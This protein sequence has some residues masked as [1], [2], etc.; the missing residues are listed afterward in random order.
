MPGS[1]AS[2][3]VAWTPRLVG[4]AAFAA[5]VWFAAPGPYWMDSQELAAAAVRLGVPHPTGFP[6]FCVVGKLA[7]LLPLGEL[8]VRV[9]W[10]TAAFAALTLAQVARLVLELAGEDGSSAVGAALAAIALGAGSTFFRAA[11][12]TEVYAPTALAVVVALR[13][14]LALLRQPSARV[15]V[16][17]GLLVGVAGIGLHSSFRLLVGPV[18]LLMIGY[19]WRRRW[20]RGAVLLGCVGALGMLA[21]LPL[22]SAS[23]RVAALDWGHPSSLGAIWDH[24]TAARIRAAYGDRMLAGA[25]LDDAVTFAGQLEADL[26]VLFLLAA[27]LGIAAL[28]PRARAFTVIVVAFVIADAAYAVVLNPMGIAERQNGVPLSVGVA[29]LAGV[30][31]ALAGRR[32]GGTLGGPFVTLTLGVALA[33]QP[34]LAGGAAKLAV[35]MSD[36]PRGWSEAALAQTPTGGIVLAHN[37][38]LAAGL[39]WLAQ[40]ERARPDAAALVRQH[41]WDRRR[42]RAVLAAIGVAGDDPLASG[43]PIRWELG[44]DRAPGPVAPDVPVGS[45]RGPPGV[46][47]TTEARLGALFAGRALDDPP[48][49]REGAR[50]YVNLGVLYAMAHQPARAAAAAERALA[51]DPRSGLAAANAALYRLQAGDAALARAHAELALARDPARATPWTVLGIL[52]A[53]SGQFCRAVER[54]D[55]ALALSPGDA[56]ASANRAEAAARCGT[57]SD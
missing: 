53:R 4:L 39:L 27:L 33:V 19:T 8:A 10:L 1:A 41:L 25:R 47:A 5:Y 24:V 16:S 45:L 15:G 11:T 23:G 36:A 30:G 6:L 20:L 42:N 43:R 34:V 38:S 54:F 46:A 55:R 40:V 18:A 49:R 17:L 2:R 44:E 26:G 32:L 37:D 3:W 21:Y 7:S 12:A 50:A 57:R 56:D 14:L 48:A 22:R 29:L 31:I 51:L 13:L 35:A 9:H 52:E 28:W